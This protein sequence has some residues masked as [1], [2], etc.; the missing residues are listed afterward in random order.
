MT[1]ASAEALEAMGLKSES[2][3]GTVEKV[4]LSNYARRVEVY[5][6]FVEINTAQ[7]VMLNGQRR[8]LQAS[9]INVIFQ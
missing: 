7:S 5:N 6:K 8:N 3:D 4:K 1:A 2:D 9:L